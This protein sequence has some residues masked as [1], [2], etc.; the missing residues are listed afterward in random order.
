MGVFDDISFEWAGHTYAL[1]S[2]RVLGA[3]ARIEDVVTFAE[4]AR[5]GSGK[6]VPLAKLAMAYGAVLRYAGAKVTDDEVYAGILSSGNAGT[7]IAA[8]TT[9][10]SMMIP[11]GSIAETKEPPKG[12]AAPAASNSSRKP[13]RSRSATGK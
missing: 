12:K 10:L 13:T 1:K 4:L 8:V 7:V 9:L 6:S 11:P 3:I 5:V 2:D